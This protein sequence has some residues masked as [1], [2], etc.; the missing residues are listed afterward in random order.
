MEAGEKRR[1]CLGEERRKRRTRGNGAGGGGFELGS[2]RERRE[3]VSDEVLEEESELGGEL[4]ETSVCEGNG[5]IGVV[6]GR[7]GE[8]RLEEIV[9]C[10]VEENHNPLVCCSLV[11]GVQNRGNLGMT[12]SFSSHA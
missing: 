9:A 3:G 11:N 10:G 12:A 1:G 7:I 2:W 8:E 4:L 5:L 6:H